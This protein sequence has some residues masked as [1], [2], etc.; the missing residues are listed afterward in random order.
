MANLLALQIDWKVSMSPR[1]YIYYEDQKTD[2]KMFCDRGVD[3]VYEAVRLRE[4]SY[5]KRLEE[6]RE[7][8]SR[9]F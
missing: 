6:N 7:E 4:E 5:K 3:P 9:H 2:R 8:R 1:E